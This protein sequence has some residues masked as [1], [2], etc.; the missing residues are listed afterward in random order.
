MGQV[1]LFE[2]KELWK[3][4]E[5]YSHTGQL[6]SDHYWNKIIEQRDENPVKFD[7][8]HVKMSGLFS[9]PVKIGEMPNSKY[10]DNFRFRF[11]LNPSRFEKNH[12]PLITDL[13]KR[14]QEARDN[15]CNTSIPEPNPN[16]SPGPDV[17]PE[18]N[19]SLL[20]L[21]GIATILTHRY[22]GKIMNSGWFN[23]KF[24]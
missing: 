14:D 2:H 11:E 5:S 24:N 1:A 6:P 15:H 8:T 19:S 18:L 16:P 3:G 21:I 20:L 10:W 7:N 23:L 9:P 12:C 4:Y 13:L 17:V 22:Y